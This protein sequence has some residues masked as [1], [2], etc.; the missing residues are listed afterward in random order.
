MGTNF[1]WFYDVILIAILIGMVFLGAKKGFVRM[2]LSL[3][4]FAISFVLAFAVSDMISVAIYD[5]V[6]SKPLEDYISTTV[7]DA[8][9]DTVITQIGKV[10][11]DKVKINGEAINDIEFKSDEAGKIT[12]NLSDVDLSKTGIGEVDLS[13]FGIDNSYD[14]SSLDLG[15]VQIYES[16]LKEHK[17]GDLIVSSLLSENIADS[18]IADTVEEILSA[19]SEKVPSLGLK[20]ADIEQMSTS[21][22]NDVMISI[23]ESSDNPGKA[24]L[25]NLVKPIVLVPLRTIIFIVLFVIIMILLSLIVRFTSIINKIPFIGSLNSFLGGV[26]GLVQG[27]LVIFVIVL[28]LNMATSMTDNSLIFL[29]EMTINKSFLFSNIYNFSF[30]DFLN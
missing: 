6:V 25:D 1:Y 19:V 17:S 14:F 10:D 12:I 29:N 16:D 20:D 9:G 13:A 23:V 4:A 7:N 18:D 5:N 15:T 11:T 21:V 30:L 28:V 8:L 22:V 2:V 24:L 27:V 26:L 3:A